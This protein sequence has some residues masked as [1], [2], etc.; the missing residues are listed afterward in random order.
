MRLLRNV[1]I[2]L[3]SLFVVTALVGYFWMKSS[4]PDYNADLKLPGLSQ[5]VEVMFDDHAVPHIYAQ[6]ERDLFMAL[7]Y[8]HAQDRL[9]Q[10]EMIRRLAD[11]RLSEVFGDKTL[12]TDKL[13][14][15]MGFREHA[16]NSVALIMRDTT[17]PHVQ[18]ALAYLRGVNHYVAF[19]KKPVEFSILGLE[20][21][22]FSMEDIE[23]IISYMGYTFTGA[24][25]AEAVATTI[26][27]R[28]GTDYLKDIFSNWPDSSW[29]IPVQSAGKQSDS[30][31]ALAFLDMADKAGDVSKN[32]PYPTYS[33]SN[34]WVVSGK[35]T[36]SGKPI[37]ANDTHIAFAQ[38]SVWYEAHLEC[39]GFSIYG[40]FLAGTPVPALGHH[41]AAGWGITMF[42]NDDMDFY[43][44]KQN[45]DNPNQVWN[46][47][48]WEDL[49]IRKETIKVKGGEDVILEVK[50]SR[51]GPILNGAFDG[52]KEYTD[53]IAMW[54]IHDQFPSTHLEAF[55]MLS[56]ADRV[57]EAREAVSLLTSPGLNIMWA[58]TTGDI[59]WW[60][61][62]KLP[63]RPA[64]VNPNLIL[65]GS[66]GADDPT[67]WV[68]FELNPQILNPARGVLYTANNQPEDMGNGLVAGYYVPSNRA[69][70]IEALIFNDRNDWT[71]ASMREV[72]ND[73]TS[74]TF[75]EIVRQILPLI[76]TTK[77]RA[78]SMAP[79]HVLAAWD[80][81]HELTDI[82]P[83]IFY[84][85]LYTIYRDVLRDELGHD[86]FKSFLHSLTLKR[87]TRSLLMNDSSRWWDDSQTP[88]RES[89]SD[90]LTKAFDEAACKLEN[91]LGDEVDQW[92]WELVHKIEHKHPLGAIPFIGPLLFNVGPFDV[93]GGQET[94]N[95]LDFPLD[96]T[97]EYKVSSGP[98]LRRI[99]DFGSK[100]D[101]FSVNPTGQSGHPL[102]PYYDDQAEMFATGGKRREY[103]DRKDVEKV[104]IGKTVLKP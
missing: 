78:E 69:R 87:N 85:F 58:D 80:G 66:S 4:R 101:R 65:D 33:G 38:P 2:G 57:P 68:P 3:F 37:L 39:P 15:T 46:K 45:P 62:G 35:K 44:E 8:I 95:N 41:D 63:I 25:K 77:L 81:T 56:H 74:A 51:H 7:G 36:K 100:D 55:Y 94:I 70:R 48:H 50:R 54:W 60:A 97:G 12:S 27:S 52:I 23:V 28:W 22:P 19:G 75:P 9:F 84:K 61:A 5:Q 24:F 90:I 88:K 83:T 21:T 16:R 40:N 14:R 71:E 79:Y 91:Q 20:G 86:A 1:I 30:S 104:K 76:D 49:Q 53:P 102:S 34:G 73:H 67:G 32:L 6:N 26:A 11:G 17:K 18:A 89:R 98:A 82:E 99:V 93:P 64:H 42:E 92:Y 103:L 96:S 29:K 10:M 13:F 31:L 47:D 72:I 59:A 43:R